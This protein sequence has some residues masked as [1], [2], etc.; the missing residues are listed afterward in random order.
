MRL[1]L[2]LLLVIACG[3]AA[4]A[5][6]YVG[7]LYGASRVVKPLQVNA[8]R[9]NLLETGQALEHQQLDERFSQYGERLAALERQRAAAD[10]TLSQL[11]GSAGALEQA[12]QE[13][14]ARLKEV[15][16]LRLDVANFTGMSSYIATEVMG[17]RMTQTAGEEPLGALRRDLS[18]LQ[19]M[20]LLNRSRLYM[21]QANYGIAA[22]DARAARAALEGLRGQ[23]PDYQSAALE[24]WIARLDLALSSL[25][26]AP[27][28]AADDLEIAW[29]ML[30]AGLPGPG[31]VETGT[32][33]PGG[34][35]PTATPYWLTPPASST[36]TALAGSATPT[37]YLPA[38]TSTPT[39]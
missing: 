14:T 2:R 38:V 23:V 1:V 33:G 20:E 5:L 13:Q 17:M 29:R 7:I 12:V 22:Q 9:L 18:V 8:E 39:P 27:V 6:L 15:D 24:A 37:P 10:E 11:Q 30:S 36:P 25:P 26:D 28:V 3:I 21:L 35:T 19:A 4:G 34:L 31:G 32:P 16:A